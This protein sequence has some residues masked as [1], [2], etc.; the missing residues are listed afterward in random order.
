MTAFLLPEQVLAIHD[1]QSSQPLRSVGA[2]KGA[3][4]RPQSAWS[5]QL[6]FPTTVAQAAVLLSSICQAQA[7]LDG[8]KRTAWV[9]CD[10]FLTLNG[11][12]LTQVSDDD[13]VALMDGI[14]RGTQDVAAVTE[15]ISTHTTTNRSEP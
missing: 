13:V 6:L 4:T 14:S 15:W 2:L 11:L 5:D 3:V 9:A 7:F 1:L 8:N 12:H 10:V